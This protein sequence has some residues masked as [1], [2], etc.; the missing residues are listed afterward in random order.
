MKRIA[1]VGL[2]LMG[3]SLGLAIKARGL[4][5]HVAG[6]TR[7]PERGRRA[8]KRGAIDTLHRTPVEAVRDAD[9]VVLCG[10]VLALPRQARECRPGLK[11]GAVVTDVGS[12]KV[13]VDKEVADVLRGSGAHFVGSHPLCGSE[14]HGIDSA[15]P[16]LYERA[17]VLVTGTP[18]VEARAV[19]L[20]RGFWKRL[21]AR[22]VEC[23]AREHDR[24]MARTS[25]L[26]HMVA[27]LLAVTVGRTGR[28]EDV[29]GYCGSGFADTSRV[30]E[31]S[32]EVWHDIVRTNRA[33]LAE[34][35]RAYKGQTERLIKMLDDGDFESIQ[36]FLEQGR[37]ARRSLVKGKSRKDV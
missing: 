24:I 26:P 11:A 37:A 2:G 28:A 9:L 7:T 20:V 17:L 12:T 13:Y 33:N 15:H 19:R 36:R 32:P 34:E 27:S 29:A 21:G 4:P 5:W 6:Y 23:E 25:H 30:A 3:G 14:Q 22:V 35:L 18:L 1:I 10:P 8:L 16:D 31:G